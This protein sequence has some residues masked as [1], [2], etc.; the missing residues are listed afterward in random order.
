MN[1]SIDNLCD[2]LNLQISLYSKLEEIENRK[3]TAILNKNGKILK[4][5]TAEEEFVIKEIDFAEKKRIGIVEKYMKNNHINAASANPSLKELTQSMDMS[6]ANRITELGMRL[7][8]SVLN[9]KSINDVNMKMMKDNVEIFRIMVDGLKGA[10]AK[11]DAYSN[12]GEHRVDQM[13]G[14]LIFNKTV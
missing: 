2:N 8:T 14:P 3:N 12:R 11:N 5:I 1:M 13:K 10:V 7:K 6:S 4:D 9:I